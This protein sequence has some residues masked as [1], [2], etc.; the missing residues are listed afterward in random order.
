MIRSSPTAVLR[1]FA[2]AYREAGL[3]GKTD[4][5]CSA[6]SEDVLR[7]R[8]DLPALAA[9]GCRRVALGLENGA[10]TALDR[11]AKQ[12]TVAQNYEGVR[13]LQQA[14]ISVFPE[15]IMFDLW[16]TLEEL[17]ASV[18]MLADLRLV[19]RLEPDTLVR[20]LLV[21]PGLPL[22]GT[23]EEH[24]VPRTLHDT[25]LR[26]DFLEPAVGTVLR[27]ML[28]TYR[29]IMPELSWARLR[30][31]VAGQVLAERQAQPVVDPWELD[32]QLSMAPVTLLE[33]LIACG[34]QPAE[35]KRMGRRCGREVT[36]LAK[37]V[38]TLERQA[39]L[40]PHR[41]DIPPEAYSHY[42]SRIAGWLGADE[43]CDWVTG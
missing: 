24:D 20:C 31:R 9:A 33:Q 39:G 37:Q 38:R 11:Y 34:G 41:G 36:A 22:A 3:T 42:Y 1:T 19:D 7:S 17:T 21:T 13:A 18:R 16:T 5:V 25:M 32:R 15:M 43:Y 12:L 4:F 40:P 14:G 2:Q 8:E 29:A 23:L 10:Q 27:G 6:R 28:D 35:A 30:L 26:W